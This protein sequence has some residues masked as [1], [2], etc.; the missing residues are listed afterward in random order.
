MS[1]NFTAYY[2]QDGKFFVGYC[3]EIEGANGQGETLEE[4]RESLQEAVKMILEI[5]NEENLAF[6]NTGFIKE[7]L[8]IDEA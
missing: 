2:Q 3:P 1:Y 5:R 4:C 7:N 6:L 8:V